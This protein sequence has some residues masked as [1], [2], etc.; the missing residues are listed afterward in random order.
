MANLGYLGANFKSFR[1]KA[2][3]FDNNR[4]NIVGTLGE[5][6]LYTLNSLKFINCIV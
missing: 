5:F 3:F 2:Y 4:I 1:K 6:N